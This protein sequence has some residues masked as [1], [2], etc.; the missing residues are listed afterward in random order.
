MHE[1]ILQWSESAH[2]NI[3]LFRKILKVSVAAEWQKN[4][5]IVTP[6]VLE[7]LIWRKKDVNYNKY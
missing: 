5:F 1:K 3:T 2:K 4:S 6:Q 7:I